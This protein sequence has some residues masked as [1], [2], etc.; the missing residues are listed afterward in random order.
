ML[1]NKIEINN[2]DVRGGGLQVDII[3]ILIV[4]IYYWNKIYT[5]IIYIFPAWKSF[6]CTPSLVSCLVS[7]G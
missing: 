1:E 3:I 2:L 5:Y 7:N 6:V 4:I